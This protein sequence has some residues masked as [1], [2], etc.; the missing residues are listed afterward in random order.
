MEEALNHMI[1][2]ARTMVEAI[3]QGIQTEPLPSPSPTEPPTPAEPAEACSLLVC[4]FHPQETLKF[5]RK[6]NLKEYFYCP[7]ST[8]H[9]FAEEGSILE[10]LQFC[11]N[12]THPEVQG[13]WDQLKDVAGTQTVLRMSRTAKNKNRVLLTSRDGN[14]R[15]FQW[16]DSPLHP[17]DK[18]LLQPISMS[19]KEPKTVPAVASG[20]FCFPPIKEFKVPSREEGFVVVENC[21]NSI[22][23]PDHFQGF[24]F[25]ECMRPAY[26]HYKSLGRTPEAYQALKGYYMKYA[27]ECGQFAEAYRHLKRLIDHFLLGTEVQPTSSRCSFYRTV[28]EQ[29][30]DNEAQTLFFGDFGEETRRQQCIQLVGNCDKLSSLF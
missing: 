11:N 30:T 21:I 1:Q 17:K 13:Q 20:L 19:S 16:V 12:Y 7:Q 26:E 29:A 2:A 8:C 27:Q 4:P 25:Q 10:T 14:S 18:E 23:S 5:E 28:E 6:E 24:R 15:F 22:C 3:D 9:I